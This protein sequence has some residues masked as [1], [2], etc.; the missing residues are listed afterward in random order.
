M[1]F[2][3]SIVNNQEID[4]DQD[5][6]RVLEDL[7][8]EE[9][10]DEKSA[11]DKVADRVEARNIAFYRPIVGT[12]NLMMTRKF[13]ELAKDGKTIPSSVLKGYLPA[14]EMLDEIITAGPAFVQTFQALHRRSK[15][16]RI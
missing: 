9:Q 2:I 8:E 10:I 6:D 1:D 4:L 3:R 7:M 11:L 12:E 13:L 14:I 16:G 5:F 15:K